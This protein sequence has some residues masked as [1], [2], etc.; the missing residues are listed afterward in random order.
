MRGCPAVWKC[1]LSRVA[2]LLDKGAA[3]AS[4]LR[5]SLAEKLLVTVVFVFFPG[6]CRIST[7]AAH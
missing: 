6:C 7:S 2:L 3:V 1:D 5:F 4:S